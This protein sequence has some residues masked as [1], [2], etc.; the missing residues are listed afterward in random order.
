MVG[1]AYTVGS[2]AARMA[3]GFPSVAVCMAVGFPLGVAAE[4]L[5]LVLVA[6]LRHPVLA[7]A[8]LQLGVEL[9]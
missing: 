5:R 3:V 9:E 8:V 7:A 6:E 2:F 1:T 4:A